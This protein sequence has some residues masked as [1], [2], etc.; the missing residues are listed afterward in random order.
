MITIYI[1]ISVFGSL[2]LSAIFKSEV[3]TIALNS[4]SRLPWFYKI[5][6][7]FPKFYAWYT[8]YRPAKNWAYKT[9]LSFL[10][11]GWHLIESLRV[12]FYCLPVTIVL[13][14]Y[15]DNIFIIDINWFYAF[16]INIPTYAFHGLI[17]EIF[18]EN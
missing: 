3:N 18:F 9:I 2:L 6:D 1:L 14:L 16:L 15:L 17:F 11:N 13:I 4:K 5:K 10:R 8:E 12:Y 7:K